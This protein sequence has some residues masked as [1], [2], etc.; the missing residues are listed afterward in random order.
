M[1]GVFYFVGFVILFIGSQLWFSA[2]CYAQEKPI[3]NFTADSSKVKEPVKGTKIH[4]IKVQVSDDIKS[5]LKVDFEVKVAGKANVEDYKIEQ[6]SL[7][8]NKDVKTN[9]LLVTIKSDSEN[10]EVE[11]LHISIKKSDNYRIGKSPL[12]VVR[13]SNAIDVPNP[14]RLSIGANFDFL[15]GPKVNDVYYDFDIFI[16]D[17]IKTKR[18]YVWGLESGIVQNRSISVD[19]TRNRRYETRKILQQNAALD[20]VSLQRTL[21]TYESK[22]RIDHL[23]LFLAPTYRFNKSFSTNNFYLQIYAEVLRRTTEV[24][25]KQEII[26]RDTSIVAVAN[27]DPDFVNRLPVKNMRYTTTEGNFG[28]G[29]KYYHVTDDVEFQAS[30]ILGVS[31]RNSG[32]LRS[33]F[34]LLG[35]NVTERSNLIRLGGEIRGDLPAY[36]PIIHIYIAKEFTLKKLTELFKSE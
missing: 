14:Y 15:D 19:S 8:F 12:H 17:V 18:G 20:T 25:R 21:S 10:E 6:S 16:H 1:K 13:I 28:L 29:L 33:G 32:F 34:Y 9:M 30:A 7:V 24:S 35:F 4:H 31:V 5:S 11:D 26:S 3:V 22:A 23:S 36:E 2:T 27:L